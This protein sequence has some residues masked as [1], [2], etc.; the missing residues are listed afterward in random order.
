MIARSARLCANT[1]RPGQGRSGRCRPLALGWLQP[2]AAPGR[3]PAPPSKRRQL[4]AR[5]ARLGSKGW[6]AGNAGSQGRKGANRTPL[7]QPEPALGGTTHHV[8]MCDND[9]LRTDRGLQ[10]AA[11][12]GHQGLHA[13]RPKVRL[14]RKPGREGGRQGGPLCA[15]GDAAPALAPPLRL[16]C[17]GHAASVLTAA[18]R[19]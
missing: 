1:D 10:N 9:T 15:R 4:Q 19:R 5:G 2:G 8:V 18:R 14:P 6:R 16:L 3:S 17:W 7:G 12:N 13:Q 11:G